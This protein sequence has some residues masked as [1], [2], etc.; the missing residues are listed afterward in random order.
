LD[1]DGGDKVLAFKRCG[2]EQCLLVLANFATTHV[3]LSLSESIRTLISGS[4]QVLNSISDP[5]APT[6]EGSIL[7]L[8]SQSV[9]VWLTEH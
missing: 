7:N 4:S 1:V 2:L 3:D 8:P 6:L 5:P 9:S